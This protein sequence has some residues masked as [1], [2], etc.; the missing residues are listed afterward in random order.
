MLLI[1]NISKRS[2]TS[3]GQTSRGFIARL[4]N[5][6]SRRAKWVYRFRD[7][8]P[9]CS[10]Q[11]WCL[12]VLWR[13]SVCRKRRHWLFRSPNRSHRVCPCSLGGDAT[14]NWRRRF[15]ICFAHPCS[16]AYGLGSCYIAELYCDFG[17]VGIIVGSF[18]YGCIFKAIKTAQLSNS[19]RNFALL[20]VMINIFKAPRGEYDRILV[21]FVNVVNLAFIIF[22]ILLSYTYIG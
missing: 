9:D 18:L 20:F 10:V 15:R 19:I 2:E 6:G 22:I 7:L 12:R 13:A 1:N 11:R 21:V 14:G 8:P 3:R 5:T 17:Y 16:V 4:L